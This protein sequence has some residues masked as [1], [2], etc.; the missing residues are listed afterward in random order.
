MSKVVRV[1]RVGSSQ[2]NVLVLIFG[3]LIVDGCT[4]VQ[5]LGVVSVNNRS[6]LCLLTSVIV[7][8]NVALS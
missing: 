2:L 6:F 4:W 3:R 5:V 8:S 7:S 1:G